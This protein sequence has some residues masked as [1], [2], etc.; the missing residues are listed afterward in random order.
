MKKILLLLLFLIILLF[1]ILFFKIKNK[2]ENLDKNITDK[3]MI[4]LKVYDID[5]EFIIKNY[6]D[7]KLWD[8]TWNLF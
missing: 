3:L 8:K 2:E 1:F 6:T 5:Y 7:P 4:D